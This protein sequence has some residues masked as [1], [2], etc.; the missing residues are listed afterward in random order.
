MCDRTLVRRL[1]LS[2]VTASMA[3]FACYFA[4]AVAAETGS[5]P[6]QKAVARYVASGDSLPTWARSAEIRTAL[7]EEAQRHGLSAITDVPS[8]GAVAAPQ[9]TVVAALRL[10]RMLAS[11]AVSPAAVDR[12]WAI[13]VP[14]FAMEAALGTL[15]A[16]GDP[17]PW[18]RSLAPEENGYRDLERALASYR[19]SVEHGGWPTLPPGPVLKLGA[20]G[21]RVAML[22]ARLRSEGDLTARRTGEEV[23]D[24][25][26]ERAVRRFQ[27]H[28]GLAVNGQVAGETLEALNVTA[29]Q[30]YRQIAA[31]M[32]RWRW[33]PHRLPTYRIEVNTAATHLTLFEDD[34][35]TLQL[36]TIVGAPNHATPA[37]T[38]NIG[39]LLLNPPWNIPAEIAAREIMPLARRDPSYL[40]RTGIVAIGDG[41]RLRQ[42]P[43]PRNALGRIK[44]EMP[45]PLDIYLHDTPNRELFQSPHRF[46]SHGCIRTEHPED[47]AMHLL[48]HEPQWTPDAIERAMSK[49]VTR[50]VS[51]EPVVPVFVVYFTAV[52]DPSGK[53]TFLD[54]VYG[55][56]PPLIAALFPEPLVL[57]QARQ[58]ASA[59]TCRAG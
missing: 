18:L 31:N 21:P 20:S 22:R 47:L 45:S 2:T 9:A 50:R 1:V 38:A 41:A 14:G 39:S 49:G 44:F 7:V 33:L 17:L 3:I 13:P 12:D 4:S 5:D 27:A 43:G 46:L 29:D 19:V 6:E 32:E 59:P 48:Q 51:I 57:S 54:D 42:L 37:L 28:H 52:A 24:L 58:P 40:G 23:F 56:D 55:R 10:A 36:R 16:V 53:P 11:G 26:T 25:E 8:D 30:R 15:A 34:H 35:A